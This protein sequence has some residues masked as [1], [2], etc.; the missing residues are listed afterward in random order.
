MAR[1]PPL[2]H[3]PMSSPAVAAA[4]PATMAGPDEKTKRRVDDREGFF[5][6]L[7]GP[8]ATAG[9]AVPSPPHPRPPLAEPSPAAPAAVA[10][11]GNRLRERER[12]KSLPLLLFLLLLLLLLYYY[13]PSFFFFFFFSFFFFPTDTDPSPFLHFFHGKATVMVARPPTD[14]TQPPSPPPVANRR[15]EEEERMGSRGR[16]PRIH[17]SPSPINPRNPKIIL[18][19]SRPTTMPWFSANPGGRRQQDPQERGRNR[20]TLFRTLL[21]PFTDQN[22]HPT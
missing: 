12:K 6:H 3:R 14:D 4:T 11:D 8:R 13:F 10:G 9:V 17:L 5:L 21:R 19:Q 20:G 15:G 7:F 18:S 1:L 22:P 16:R 2:Y